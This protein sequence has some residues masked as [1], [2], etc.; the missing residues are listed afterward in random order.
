MLG[1][2]C[3]CFT[4]SVVYGASHRHLVEL[5][6]PVDSVVEMQNSMYYLAVMQLQVMIMQKY[7]LQGPDKVLY[8]YITS[9]NGSHAD[10]L[11]NLCRT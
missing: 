2:F 11:I 1:F 6:I 9:L 5:G 10:L 8:R 3:Q 4:L 7:N